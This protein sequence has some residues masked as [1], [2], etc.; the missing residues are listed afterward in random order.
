LHEA[1]EL[2]TAIAQLTTPENASAAEEPKR[3]K[4]K[5]QQA[6]QKLSEYDAQFQ[7]TL[8][9]RRDPDNGYQE[10]GLIDD[11]KSSFALFE[12]AIDK[13]ILPEIVDS[14]TSLADDP[15]IKK[16]HEKLMLTANEIRKAI[17]DDMFRSITDAKRNH[18]RSMIIV[19]TCSLAAIFLMV[20]MLYF[21]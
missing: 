2:R 15:D 14:H 21:F 19:V 16:S 18:H 3:M 1:E 6:R 11:L 5:L 17:Y 13:A 4:A 9:R 7:D 8:S 10:S 20:G 12:K